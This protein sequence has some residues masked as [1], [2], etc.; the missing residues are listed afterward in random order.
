[1]AISAAPDDDKEEFDGGE[2]RTHLDHFKSW[3]APIPRSRP[4]ARTRKII[5][6]NLPTECDL[7]LVQ[8]LVYGG[9]IDTFSLAPSKT[10]A[11]VTFVTADACDAMFNAHPNGLV[12]KNPRTR[13]NHVVCIDKAQ[14]VDVVSGILQAYLDC[15]ASRVVRATGADEDWGMRALYKLAE[16]K[17]R[18]V[19]TIVDTYRDQVRSRQSLPVTTALIVLF[20]DLPCSQ[21]RT[22]IFRFTN[23]ADAVNF[24]GQLL[25]A[26]DWEMCNIQFMDD[27]VEKA[28]GVHLEE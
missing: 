6:S 13:R 25:R 16:S 22:I 14:D 19:E 27:P 24:R 23:I 9:A 5:L 4:A 1:M 3:G 11:Y 21:I 18:K 8:C 20:T 2:D 10:T 17:N 28:T 26:E 7:T 12:F 15:Q